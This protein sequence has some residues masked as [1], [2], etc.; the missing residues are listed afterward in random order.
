MDERRNMRAFR[1]PSRDR[2][3]QV[4]KALREAGGDSPERRETTLIRGA[5]CRQGAK[6]HNLTFCSKRPVELLRL[7]LL[8]RAGHILA[9]V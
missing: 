3:Q 8:Q 9:K 6:K 1:A 4:W 5:K 2:F 7:R